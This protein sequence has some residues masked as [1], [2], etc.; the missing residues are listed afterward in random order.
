MRRWRRLA[1]QHRRRVH[2][3]TLTVRLCRKCAKARGEVVFVR[4][5]FAMSRVW[6]KSECK[7]AGRVSYKHSVLCACRERTFRSNVR[8]SRTFC[9]IRLRTA[10]RASA[11]T[12]A[13]TSIYKFHAYTIRHQTFVLAGC[14]ARVCVIVTNACAVGG[15]RPPCRVDMVILMLY[16][17]QHAAFASSGMHKNII[18]DVCSHIAFGWIS[19][20]IENVCARCI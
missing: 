11:T 16:A 6:R 8:Q 5:C 4:V 10:R 12:T 13:T 14:G 9:V 3:S 18:I 15:A 1:R 2:A 17:P 19:M 20:H 7:N